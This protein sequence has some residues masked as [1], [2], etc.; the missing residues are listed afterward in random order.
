MKLLHIDSS[1]LG[2]HSVTRMLTAA[3]VAEARKRFPDLTV[4]YRDLDT[5]PISHFGGEVLAGADA[6]A[7]ADA[8]RTLQ[9]FLD[10]DLIVI[11]APM[12]NF[13][14]PSRL[15]AWIDRVMVAGKTFK[16]TES[17][18]VGLAGDK[19]VLVAVGS[20]GVHAD[21]P[22]DFVEPYLRTAFGFM[23]ITDIDFVRAEGVALSPQ[24]R[25]EAVR[26]VLDELPERCAAA[27]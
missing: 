4:E 22:S 25:D 5:D 8:Q 3:A 21:K 11:G 24:H 6:E 1:A 26:R 10:A 12:Y 15:K 14:I 20:G 17:G 16:Y 19:R 9:Q 27:A 2:A 18:P 7:Q 23:G 13:T